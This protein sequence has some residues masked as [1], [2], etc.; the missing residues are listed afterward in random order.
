MNIDFKNMETYHYFIAGGAGLVVISI[1]L[2]FLKGSKVRVS[3]F[4][5]AI[6]GSIALGFGAGVVTLGM[7]GYN[8]KEKEKEQ[9]QAG[10]PPAGG[11][12]GGGGMGGGMG[13][14][15][16]GG[17]KGG[18]GGGGK[19]AAPSAKLQLAALVVKLNQLTGK[20]LTIDVGDRKAKVAEQLKDLDT[21]ETLND[22]AAEAKVKALMELFKPEESTLT[23]AGFNLNFAGNVGKGKEPPANP[24]TTET[25]KA[26]L[27]ALQ[28]RVSK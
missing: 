21:I 6:I 20:T 1:L 17:G 16:G 15:I 7:L 28:E 8:W 24:F 12:M 10:A 5:A 11:G 14:G 18:G 4:P 13:G 27:K 26:A 22:E 2:Y 9:A 3:A 23:S 19:A 25:N